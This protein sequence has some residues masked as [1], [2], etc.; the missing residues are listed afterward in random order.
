MTDMTNNP[1]FQ[2]AADALC[3]MGYSMVVFDNEGRECL[4]VS[5]SAIETDPVSEGAVKLMCVAWFLSNEDAL[6]QALAA[7]NSLKENNYAE[8]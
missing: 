1:E 8:A 3:D 6:R 5:D 7:V 2:A 4:C